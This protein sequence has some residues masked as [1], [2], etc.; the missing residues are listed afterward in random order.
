MSPQVNINV[1]KTITRGRDLAGGLRL[2]KGAGEDSSDLAGTSD[3]EEWPR[4]SGRESND[5]ARR[6][7]PPHS[8]LL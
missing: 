8:P 7:D 3:D 4:G 5:Q 6:L 2:W 1:I